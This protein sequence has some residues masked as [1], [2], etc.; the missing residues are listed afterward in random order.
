MQES[1][2]DP[3]LPLTDEEGSVASV[4]FLRQG[5]GNSDLDAALYARGQFDETS[6]PRDHGCQ[7]PSEPAQRL[8]ADPNGLR[9]DSRQLFALDAAIYIGSRRFHLF[10][11]ALAARKAAYAALV[12]QEKIE[13]AERN[14][15]WLSAWLSF[16]MNTADLNLGL[17]VARRDLPLWSAPRV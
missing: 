15:P 11:E 14:G 12:E 13:L 5:A 6:P 3:V 17:G 2:L 10:E 16:L 8:G 7:F 1:M 4:D 9:L